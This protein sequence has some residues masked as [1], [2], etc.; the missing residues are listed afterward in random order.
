MKRIITLLLITFLLMACSRKI[1]FIRTGDLI[2]RDYKDT[3]AID[4]SNV[5]II[6][7]V[8]A[9]DN[10]RHLIF[11]TGADIV[12]LPP[13]SLPSKRQINMFDSNGKTQLIDMQYLDSLIMGN[14]KIKNIYAVEIDFPIVLDCFGNGVLG[15]NVIKAS[16]WL[17]EN[18][19]VVFSNSPFEIERN[20]SLNLFYY[21]ANRLHANFKINGCA[22]DTCLIDYGGFFDIELPQSSFEELREHIEIN[23][24]NNELGSSVGLHG[25]ATNSQTTVNCN[26][27][28][29]GLEIDS[30]NIK[31][32]ES[33]EK[34]VGITFMKRFTQ[35][36][37]NNSTQEIVFGKLK[38]IQPGQNSLNKNL[39]SF[40]LIDQRFVVDYVVLNDS[41]QPALKI[42]DSFIEINSKKATDF[43]R[44]CD[45]LPWKWSLNES[46][47]LELKNEENELMTIKNWR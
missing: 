3:I 28:F 17:I 2:S 16:N 31:V 33:G 12:C 32:K 13:D 39:Y 14:Q 30:V 47:L 21:G 27:D 25:K 1:N 11:D 7:P 8:K 19:K 43:E 15:N 37:I 42:G 24:L 20:F 4:P 6:I 41:L 9:N 5:Y 40:D 45:F 35:V 18:D 36:A 29:N 46:E 10:Q 23:S 22:I 44:Y 26:I 34:R 38:E